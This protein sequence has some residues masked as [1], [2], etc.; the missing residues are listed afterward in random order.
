MPPQ[1][2]SN[3]PIREALALNTLEGFESTHIVGDLKMK[4]IEDKLRTSTYGPADSDEAA[5]V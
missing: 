4:G 5:R 3:P 1:L 2:K